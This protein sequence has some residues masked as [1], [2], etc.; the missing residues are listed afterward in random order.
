V[1]C[2]CS[3]SETCES[4]RGVKTQFG[5]LITTECVNDK[6]YTVRAYVSL[7]D[8]KLLEDK[9]L[10]ADL[11]IDKNRSY[12]VFSGNVLHE[13]GCPERLYLLDL[14][15]DQPKVFAFGVKAACNEFQWASWGK[16]G[17]VIALKNN[18]K[19][20][21]KSGKI[22]P[23]KADENLRTSIQPTMFATD[24]SK[25]IPFAEEIPLPK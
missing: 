17:S 1:C 14:S 13:T 25:L 5:R 22:T 6:G 23:P 21:Y 19:F 2:G 7:N 4:G 16:N 12:W 15:T 24:V 3:A 10:S 18:V 11:A 20:V 8:T 9:F